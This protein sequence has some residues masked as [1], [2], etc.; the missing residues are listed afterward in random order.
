MPGIRTLLMTTLIQ[1]WF[2][3]TIVVNKSWIRSFIYLENANFKQIIELANALKNINSV[4]LANNNIGNNNRNKFEINAWNIHQKFQHEAVL[5]AMTKLMAFAEVGHS[6]HRNWSL[7]NSL[8]I[9]NSED[10]H[11]QHAS[12][13]VHHWSLIGFKFITMVLFHFRIKLVEYNAN[14]RHS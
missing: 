1:T 14:Y 12:K 7:R 4:L 13:G 9:H 10:Q 11:R 5:G 3:K 6:Y 8:L 2:C